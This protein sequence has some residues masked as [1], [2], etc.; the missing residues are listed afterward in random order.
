MSTSGIML[1]SPTLALRFAS[2]MALSAALLCAAG[3]LAAQGTP[4]KLTS[5]TSPSASQAGGALVNVIG[6]GFPSGTIPPGN[7]TVSLVP[8]TSGGGPSA[9]TTATGVT[10]IFGST[11]RV[12]FQIPIALT[13][14]TP[15]AYLVSISGMTSTNAAFASSNSAAL[16]INPPSTLTLNPNSG[17]PG[18]MLTVSLTGTFTNYVQGATMAN[19]GA[20]ISVGGAAAGGFGN[21]TVTSPTNATASIQIS[22]GATGSRLVTVQTGVQAATA[23][24]SLPT[25][26]P[27]VANP[28]G[29][30]SGTVGQPVSFD[31]SASSDPNGSPLTFSWDFG[32][33]TSPGSGPT[34][35]HTYGSKGTFTV[36]LTVTDGLGLSNMAT[37]TATISP[38]NT[39]PVANA[40]PN[41]QVNAGTLVHL[42]GSKSN[43]PDGDPLTFSWSFVSSLWAAWRS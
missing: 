11:R 4:V 12:T 29:P 22:S 26:Q 28:G 7:V 35:M 30:Y 3:P 10:T 5:P 27:P 16:T 31:G 1:K 13:T 6:S 33:G 39:P 20:G 9:N 18:Q 14:N 25:S 2:L 36:T 8:A 23:L 40:G 15:T 34:P 19:F 43:D 38:A 41:Q 42:D 37:T 24:F 21:V 32:D 17:L